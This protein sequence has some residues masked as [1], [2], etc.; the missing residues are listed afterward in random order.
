MLGKIVLIV[1]V[2]SGCTREILVPSK[3]IIQTRIVKVQEEE[4]IRNIPEDLKTP[5]LVTDLK[6]LSKEE[7][8]KV[9]NANKKSL[10]D[11]ENRRARS[12][13]KLKKDGYN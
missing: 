10:I 3:P 8:V 9:H 1:L 13:D 11:C 6:I 12:V 7:L 2:L 4:K 5:C